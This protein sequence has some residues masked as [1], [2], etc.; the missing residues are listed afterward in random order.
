MKHL[1]FI[2]TQPKNIM[3]PKIINPKQRFV[4]FLLISLS[5]SLSISRKETKILPHLH[6]RN[7]RK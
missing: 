2:I 6:N 5:S 3:C 4:I 1:D 7:K